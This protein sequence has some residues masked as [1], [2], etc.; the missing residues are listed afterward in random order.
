MARILVVDDEPLIS[1]MTEDWLS[2]LGHVVVGPAYNLAAALK[3]AETDLDAAIVDVSLGHEK[4]YPLADALSARAAFRSRWP[5]DMGRKGS[6]RS[7]AR[8]PRSA[9]QYELATFRRVI[10]ELLAQSRST[11]PVRPR[12]DERYRNDALTASSAL[13]PG[14]IHN[15][16][17]R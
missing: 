11:R 5:R 17:A 12:R 13:I 2:E 8:V 1:A 16:R 7:T 4:S 15:R 9:S 6:T 14:T 3:L 10:D